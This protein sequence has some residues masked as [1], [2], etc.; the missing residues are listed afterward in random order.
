MLRVSLDSGDAVEPNDIELTRITEPAFLRELVFELDAAVLR[1]L[2]IGRRIGW[3]GEQALWLLG[4]LH[5]VYFDF[6]ASEA[7]GEHEP[8]AFHHGIA[9]SVKLLHSAV[10]HLHAL[11]PSLSK[12]VL[13]TWATTT[14]PVHLRLWMAAGRDK[15]LVNAVDVGD[16]LLAATDRQ[17]WN[18]NSY[19]EVSELR[20]R[21]FSDLTLPLQQ[22]LIARLLQGPPRSL[23][24]RDTSQVDY[25]RA[26]SFAVG[27]ELKRIELAGG[28]LPAE[29]LAWRVAHEAHAS[30]AGEM[31][32]IDQGFMSAPR[33]LS[34]GAEPDAR[35]SELTGKERLDALESALTA[36]SRAW[37]DDTERKAGSW[38]SI[39]TNAIALIADFEITPDAGSNYPHVWNRFGWAHSDDRDDARDNTPRARQATRAM[40]AR[41]FVLL[42]KLSLSSANSA[43]DGIAFW[44]SRWSEHVQDVGL[45]ST[46]WLRLWPL[47][48]TATNRAQPDSEEPSLNVVIRQDTAKEPE[49]LDTLNSPAGQFV[50]AFLSACGAQR[51][52]S[53]T[54]TDRR[55]R[56]IRDVAYIASH[57][58]GLITR[59]RMIQ[60]LPWFLR[61]APRWTKAHLI[62]P[63]RQNTSE[64]TVLWRAFAMRTH[65]T[66]VIRLLGNDMAERALDTS[67]G[68]RSRQSLV[69]SLVVEVLHALNEGR[70]PA[71]P[72]E[73]VHQLLRAL[74]DEGRVEAASIL[75]QYL[76]EMSS[77]AASR[78]HSKTVEQLFRDSIRPFITSVWPHERSLVVPGI[79]RALVDVPAAAGDA[80]AEAV[81]AIERFLVGFDCWSLIDFGLYGAD[82][83]ESRLSR[84][85]SK[86]KAEALLR[87]LD[88]TIGRTDESAIPA[89]LGDALAQ[90]R[91]IAPSLID[92]PRYRRLATLSR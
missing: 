27:R 47:A 76:R 73:A 17:F 69:F 77:P 1:G 49:D 29:A 75:Q 30:A 6:P 67:L 24:P 36:P 88:A 32:R 4:G 63:L 20:A 71:I 14:S 38:I 33:V 12:D 58:S 78:A 48:V 23:W 46:V 74:D 43:I 35:Y 25:E 87:L 80:F 89:D 31:T 7:T 5:R 84:V 28:T 2:N 72:C 21:R 55:L 34:A 26:R 54:F 15:S 66:D 90:I 13:R 59:H 3:D 60:A 44:L 57:R 8:D 19:P 82:G 37:N 61:V 40:A 86:A 52:G 68:R 9:P 53:R 64:A 50:G 65:R 70:I 22:S 51:K 56:R 85:D 62:G 18:V 41:V 81:D 42:S 11:A 79:A 16:K 10:M 39:R 91:L 45:F 92:D 83:A